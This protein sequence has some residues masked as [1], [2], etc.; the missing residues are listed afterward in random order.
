MHS[1]IVVNV[2]QCSEPA[3][4]SALFDN[5]IRKT[6]FEPADG[7]L[8]PSQ[9]ATHLLSVFHVSCCRENAKAL[10][11]PREGQEVMVLPG[12]AGDLVD[13]LKRLARDELLVIAPGV[14]V[15]VVTQRNLF[16]CVRVVLAGRPDTDGNRGQHGLGSKR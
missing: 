8:K 7:R 5:E 3:V 6:R 2:E 9:V 11:A 10:V 14:L 15:S 12:F 13:L 4:L 16:R 1:G